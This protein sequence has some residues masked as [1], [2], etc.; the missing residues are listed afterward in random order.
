MNLQVDNLS[1]TLGKR[2]VLDAVSF[3]IE[4][5]QVIG[6]RKSVV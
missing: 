5:G 1:V 6:D 2:Q 4:P 3:D